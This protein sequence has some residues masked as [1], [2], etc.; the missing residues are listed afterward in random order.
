MTGTELSEAFNYLQLAEEQ[1]IAAGNRG[2]A[3]RTAQLH[4]SISREYPL[5][6][7]ELCPDS[8]IFGSQFCTQHQF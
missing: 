1:F 3:E 6:Q 5:R 2:A 8:A 7:C 4:K